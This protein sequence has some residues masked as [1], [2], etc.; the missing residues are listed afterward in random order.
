MMKIRIQKKCCCSRCD[1]KTAQTRYS[2][3]YAGK[4]YYL[5]YM[6][7]ECGCINMFPTKAPKIA[8]KYYINAQYCEIST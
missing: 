8:T 7:N 2:E 5:D 1:K 3:G 4:Q 6:C